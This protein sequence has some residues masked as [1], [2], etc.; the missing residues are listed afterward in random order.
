MSHSWMVE[1]LCIP[2]NSVSN[3]FEIAH[4]QYCHQGFHR[5]FARISAAFYSRRLSKLLRDYISNC[6]VL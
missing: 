2:Q 1:R 3:I 6:L 5:F 4:D